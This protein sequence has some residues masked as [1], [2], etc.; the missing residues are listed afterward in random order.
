MKGTGDNTKR[1]LLQTKEN[2][3]NHSKTDKSPKRWNHRTCK[4][5]DTKYLNFEPQ[6]YMYYQK[7]IRRVVYVPYKLAHETNA[8]EK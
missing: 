5:T 2:M 1:Q 8:T 6:N 4:L 7:R 3:C